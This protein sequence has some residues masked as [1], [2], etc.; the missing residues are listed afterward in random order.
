MFHAQLLSHHATLLPLEFVST[1]SNHILI[2]QLDL[3]HGSKE[4][5]PHGNEARRGWVTSTCTEADLN[6]M[7]IEGIILDQATAGWRP[8]AGERFSTPNSQEIVVF[9]SYFV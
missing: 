3:T 2:T 9:E 8:A 1:K 4:S 5:Q 7:V 6:G